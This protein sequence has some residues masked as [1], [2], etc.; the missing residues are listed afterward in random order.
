[1]LARARW[2]LHIILDEFALS[3]VLKYNYIV[4]SDMFHM[5]NYHHQ[6]INMDFTD[7]WRE[8]IRDDIYLSFKSNQAIGSVLSATARF[9]RFGLTGEDA[10]QEDRLERNYTDILWFNFTL[11]EANKAK[12]TLHVREELGT[13]K[14]DINAVMYVYRASKIYL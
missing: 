8:L 7:G 6:I 13:V 4:F 10:V 3:N 9:H 5:L 12:L 1:M 14:K 11:K 2:A